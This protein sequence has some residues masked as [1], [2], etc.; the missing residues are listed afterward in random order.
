MMMMM[1][2]MKMHGDGVGAG[3]SCEEYARRLSRKTRADL[4][5][6]E[7]LVTRSTRQCPR[8]GAPTEKNGGCN[9]M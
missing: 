7:E 2:M 5:A 9:H 4:V 8:C 1:M 3:L 6:S